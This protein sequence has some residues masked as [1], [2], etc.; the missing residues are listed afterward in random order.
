[1]VFWENDHENPRKVF[2]VA[3]VTAIY[4]LWQNVQIK[5]LGAWSGG[6][7]SIA[8]PINNL[9]Q[10]IGATFYGDNSILLFGD[11]LVEILGN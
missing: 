2:V 1:M 4:F 8:T 9:G 3:P 10:V 5:D 7:R 11:H 6:V